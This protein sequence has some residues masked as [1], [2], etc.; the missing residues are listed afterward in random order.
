MYVEFA[1]DMNVT[2]MT[3]TLAVGTVC[4]T[5]GVLGCLL[6]GRFRHWICVM[7]CYARDR[8]SS[9]HAPVTCVTRVSCVTCVTP[10]HA[11]LYVSFLQSEY[12]LLKWRLVSLTSRNY[13]AVFVT[14]FLVTSSVPVRFAVAPTPQGT[15]ARA[16]NFYKR[17]GT[18]GTMSRRTANK[19]LTKLY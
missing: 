1:G 16:P 17:L 14:D 4:G 10:S 11:V 8:Y 7:I 9:L 6:L 2:A 3:A 5:L 13:C 19:K 15:G 18:R 12:G